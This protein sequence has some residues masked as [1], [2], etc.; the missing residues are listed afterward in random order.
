ML[1]RARGPPVLL[2]ILVRAER[3]AESERL[4]VAPVHATVVRHAETHPARL[5]PLVA[6]PSRLQPAGVR[7]FEAL[8]QVAVK[9]NADARIAQCAERRAAAKSANS[10]YGRVRVARV[11]REV[12]PSVV[13]VVFEVAV[14]AVRQINAQITQPSLRLQAKTQKPPKLL[15]TMAIRI[16]GSPQRSRSDS[17]SDRT[18][19][20]RARTRSRGRRRAGAK[21]RPNAGASRAGQRKR[22]AP[23]PSCT[24][25]PLRSITLT[26]YTSIKVR[27]NNC[28]DFIDKHEGLLYFSIS[29]EYLT[30]KIKMPRLLERAVQPSRVHVA[31]EPDHCGL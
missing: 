5:L 17:D 15:Q 14:G 19:R 20:E 8:H 31:P 23:L 22:N 28:S 7:R 21:P 13:R 12:V 30:L 26:S 29:F 1:D 9:R 27:T 4:G 16:R 24:S 18:R 3:L 6:F 11:P 25:T 10:R 2:Q